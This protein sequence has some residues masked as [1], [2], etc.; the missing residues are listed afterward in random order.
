MAAGLLSD[1]RCS[2]GREAKEQSPAG[3]VSQ[4]DILDQSEKDTFLTRAGILIT[5]MCQPESHQSRL[6]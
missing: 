3:D 2:S 6:V 4:V 1:H 5:S